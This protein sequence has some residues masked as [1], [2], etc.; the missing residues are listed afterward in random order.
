[1]QPANA[2][3]L[4]S[5]LLPEHDACPPLI[6]DIADEVRGQ[7]KDQG[8][9]NLL[10][11][12]VSKLTFSDKQLDELKKA[13]KDQVNGTTWKNQRIGRITASNLYEVQTKVKSISSSKG[14]T[15][16][17]NYTFAC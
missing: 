14:F 11:T 3:V 4:L 1:M 12:F 15:Q 9:A 6:I 13:I 7:S 8:D 5:V 10:D 2:V 17:P 16:T